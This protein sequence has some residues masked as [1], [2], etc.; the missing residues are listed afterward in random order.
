MKIG[1]VMAEKSPRQKFSR[2]HEIFE[3]QLSCI[4]LKNDVE[5]M[6][7]IEEMGLANWIW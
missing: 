7:L 1:Q 6:Q 4:W 5:L 3:Q 2:F